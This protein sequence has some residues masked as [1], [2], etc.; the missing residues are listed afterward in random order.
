MPVFEHGTQNN[1]HLGAAYVEKCL[2]RLGGAEIVRNVA[3]G[4][5]VNMTFGVDSEIIGLVHV[6][7]TNSIDPNSSILG[8]SEDNLRACGNFDYIA[9][10]W[11][12][13]ID[14][15]IIR[16]LTRDAAIEICE[17]TQ[18]SQTG[19]YSKNEIRD[20]SNRE[21]SAV[22]DSTDPNDVINP[23]QFF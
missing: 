13:S 18:N 11:G 14:R 6:T 10:V 8:W 22:Y 1:K 7:C 19:Q 3:T 2:A 17:S 4:C 9:F 20:N 5:G 21:W 16:V 15:V 23:G 12:D